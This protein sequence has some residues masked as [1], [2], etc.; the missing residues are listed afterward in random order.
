MENAKVRPADGTPGITSH[1]I[2]MKNRI[3]HYCIVLSLEQE[4]FLNSAKS[5]VDRYRFVHFL[6]RHAV[7]EQTVCKVKGYSVSL[8]VG[9]VA[10][11]EG[12]L[13]R[14][15][16]CERKTIQRLVE[17]MRALQLVSTNSTNRATVFTLLYLS[18]WLVDGYMVKNPYYQRPLART[19]HEQSAGVPSDITQI[20]PAK[21]TSSLCSNEKSDGEE[22]GETGRKMTDR[23]KS[24]LC[25]RTTDCFTN[26]Q[27]GEM[28]PE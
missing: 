24:P 7:I 28:S 11:A 26:L 2:K 12:E 27:D 25:D 3:I 9:Q 6:A 13:A 5:G 17:N 8:Q 23:Q 16:G 4:D 22:I 19:R 21:P 10:F 15:F 14:L 1:S 18:G 20:S